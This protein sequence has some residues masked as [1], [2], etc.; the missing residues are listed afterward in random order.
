LMARKPHWLIVD[1][2]E[3]KKPAYILPL[4]DLVYA[5]ADRSKDEI[6]LGEIPANR[7][8]VTS[9]LLQATLKEAHDKIE[10]TG[11]QALYV[12]RI[13]AP[14]TDSVAGLVLKEDI[15]SYYQT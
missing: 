14:M 1:D 4:T 11:V 5:L 6:D 15:E 8:D 10:V 7:K 13:S 3:F 2:P 12:N 9:I